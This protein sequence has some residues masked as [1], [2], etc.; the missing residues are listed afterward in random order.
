MS[1]FVSNS[2]ANAL[3][4]EI[5]K[6]KLTVTDIM[7]SAASAAN[8]GIPYLYLGTTTQ[9]FTNGS[10]YECQEV[11]PATDP[12]TYEWVEKYQSNVDLTYYKRIWGGTEAGWDQLTDEQKANYEYMFFDGDDNYYLPVVDAVTKDD[13]HPVTSNAVAEEVEDL[14]AEIS[15]IVNVYGAKNLLPNLKAKQ[16][17]NGI[18]FI[19]NLDGSVTVNGTASANIGMNIVTRYKGLP[20]GK[21]IFSKGISNDDAQVYLNLYNGNTLVRQVTNL[22]GKTEYEFNND[23]SGY[24]SVDVGVYVVSG[25]SLSS[26]TFY[27]MIRLAS[28]KDD[29]FEPF[30]PTN[31]NTISSDTNAELGAHQYID[32]DLDYLKLRNTS[33]TWDG[34]S[35]TI[36]GVTF[37][38]NDDLSISATGQATAQTEFCVHY[39]GALSGSILKKN[40]SYIASMCS[41]K[42][43]ETTFRMVVYGR[44]SGSHTTFDFVTNSCDG[45]KFDHSQDSYYFNFAIRIM[46]GHDPNGMTFYPLIR[47]ATD[48]STKFTPYAKTNKELTDVY[49][50]FSRRFN[51]VIQNTFGTAV[52]PDDWKTGYRF[53]YVLINYGNME[54]LLAP[55]VLPTES[56]AIGKEYAIAYNDGQTAVVVTFIID[57]SNNVTLTKKKDPQSKLSGAW[58]CLMR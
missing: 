4:S 31:F 30:A 56:L 18:E 52:L 23:Y 5:G 32:Y 9:D 39:P 20:S 43:S 33:G 12:K 58:F 57:S 29:T 11:T 21:L 41:K 47:L 45:Y 15:D 3:M 1:N 36:N 19:C 6:K 24:D 37:T 54:Y 38:V 48:P 49:G 55:T 44:N 28:I 22:I 2:D 42:G 10:I 25:K 35:Y 26:V 51:V 14:D 34:N 16:Y 27:P 40:T 8:E 13:M 53:I 50:L 46:N 17:A 7:P